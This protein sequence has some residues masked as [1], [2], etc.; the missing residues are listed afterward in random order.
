MFSW[1]F[2]LK[3]G[4]PLMHLL[5]IQPRSAEQGDPGRLVGTRMLFTQSRCCQKACQK[6]LLFTKS[7]HFLTQLE[8]S[9]LKQRGRQRHPVRCSIFE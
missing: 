3:T 5:I 6:L 9:F 4:M 8:Q 2:L 1:I 7:I